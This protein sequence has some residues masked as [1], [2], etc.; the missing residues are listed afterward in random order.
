[1]DDQHVLLLP[2]GSKPEFDL[3]RELFG[4]LETPEDD[5][6]GS[7]D[8]RRDALKDSPGSG[9][10]DRRRSLSEPCIV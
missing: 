1:M 2:V 10:A 7:F 8:R 3:G 9:T 5:L 4:H 6:Q